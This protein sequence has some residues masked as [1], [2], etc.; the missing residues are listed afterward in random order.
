MM[1]LI[2]NLSAPQI[3]H[4]LRQALQLLQHHFWR[5]LL[6]GLIFVVLVEACSIIPYCGFSLKIS[7]AALLS[8]QLIVMLVASQN[9]QKPTPTELLRGLA[10]RLYQQPGASLCL[11]LCALLSFCCGIAFLGCM[12]GWHSV[13]FFFSKP[14]TQQAPSQFGW[15]YFKL[16]TALS[17]LVFFFLPFNL[18]VQQ[19]PPHL[20]VLTCLRGICKNPG[21]AL[22]MLTVLSLCELINL[23]L[24]KFLGKPALIIIALLAIYLLLWSAAIRLTSAR[25][26]YPGVCH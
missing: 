13:L 9:H 11:C 16:G 24:L 15:L 1:P 3:L 26:I 10:L 8:A 14:G 20:A 12:E 17:G 18:Y 19:L 23:N 2:T 21:L 25:K 7:L 22:A 4:S 6:I 5:W